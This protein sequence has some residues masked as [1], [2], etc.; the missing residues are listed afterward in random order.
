[1]KHKKQA[2]N[3][4]ERTVQW[5]VIRGNTPDTLN[6]SLEIAMLQEELNELQEAVDSNNPVGIFDALMDLEFVLRGTCGKFGLTPEMQ[7]DGYEAVIQANETKSATKNADGK[8][9]KPADFVGPEARLQ[10]ILDKRG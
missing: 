6:W 4:I 5:N 2:F 7:V 8:I 3:H 9:T 10:T 1:M